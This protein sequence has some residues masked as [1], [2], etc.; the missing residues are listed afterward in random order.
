MRPLT[1]FAAVC[2]VL[3]SSPAL[4]R[5][6]TVDD[7]L[8]VESVGGAFVSPGGRWLVIERTAPYDTASAYDDDVWEPL[9]LS[10]LDLVDLAS[11]GRPHAPIEGE[12][13][14]G[15][16]PGPFSPNGRL[17]AVFRLKGHSSDL[18]VADL[19]GRTVRWLGLETEPG[20]WGRSVQWRSDSELIA[21]AMAKGA[22][23]A[24]FNRVWAQE[25]R[26]TAR[27]AEAASGKAATD[28]AVG[29]G[30][31]LALTPQQPQT[32]LLRI[33]ASSG[34]TKTLASGNFLD[35]EVSASGRFVA[36]L[37][38]ETPVQPKASDIVR[39]GTSG[40]RR[41][42]T[43]VDLRT[44]ATARPCPELDLLTHLLSWAPHRDEMLVYGRRS[45]DDWA[46]GALMRIDAAT[47]LCK[48]IDTRGASPAVLY[49]PEGF[50]TV[51]ADWMGD[52]PIL[53]AQANPTSAS[54]RYDWYRLTPRGSVNLTAQMAEPPTTLVA[55]DDHGLIALDGRGASRVDRSGRIRRLAPAFYRPILGA[56]PGD[57]DRLTIMPRR[58]PSA[59]LTD[60]TRVARVGEH[61]VG[62]LE[63]LE[64][65]AVPLA[66]SEGVL[67]SEVTDA[68]GLSTLTVYAGGRS[69][70]ILQVNRAYAGIDFAE[71]RPVRYGGPDGAPRT[72]WLYLPS[73]LPPERK[74]PLVV[75]PYP[76]SVYANPPRAYAPGSAVLQSN[77]Q[78]LVGAGYAVLVPSLPRDRTSHEPAAGLAD[79]ILQAVDAAARTGLVDTD[80]M[81]L[82][83]HSF[84]GYAV[85]AAAT[86]TRRFRSVIAS[87]A[88]TDL[89]SLGGIFTP[90]ARS[91]PENGLSV[92]ASA[93][94]IE[95]GQANLGGPPSTDILRF[96]R[97]SPALNA[98]QIQSPVLLIYGDQ[99]F[100]P[101]SQG[102]EMFSA[103]YRQ[104]KDAVLLTLW[105]EG[106]TATSPAN[107]RKMYDWILWWLGQTLGPGLGCPPRIAPRR[108]SVYTLGIS[109][110]RDADDPHHAISIQS[111]PGC[112]PA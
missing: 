85:L 44:G 1:R 95:T 6:F 43:L 15:V 81:A 96:A 55:V 23:P 69:T 22:R 14:E 66:A 39:V 82:W 26:P 2:L 76:G 77:P 104:R 80:R 12:A 7:L 5:P 38:D 32:R 24:R 18:G 71:V 64:A 107:V 88:P 73:K 16:S 83:G 74:A 56:G 100:V 70:T 4:G 108:P 8:K 40:W 53:L 17:M 111:I 46:D 31:F 109:Q 52:D 68:H 25:E 105:G 112:P 60:G 30:R 13:G 45:G 67:V 75:L 91:A 72:G 20:Y 21:I 47:G 65:G 101:L 98:E 84:G 19:E 57:G 51:R 99:D 50:P 90:A 37:G 61:G 59:W 92:T 28:T 35:L 34:R 78:V 79:E 3:V 63:A 41:G 27:W 33:D 49:G 11:P 103:L 48:R 97:D 62:A 10:R 54:P 87:A 93:G 89:I 9:A 110:L 42:L 94:W 106:H 36:V 29:S 102:E 86:Q 58:S